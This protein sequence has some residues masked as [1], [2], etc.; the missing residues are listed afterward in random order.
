MQAD[1]PYDLLLENATATATASISSHRISGFL[2]E[3]L[4]P[5]FKNVTAT[6][7]AG[8]EDSENF[9]DALFIACVFPDLAYADDSDFSLVYQSGFF[10]DL[11]GPEIL[12]RIVVKGFFYDPARAFA[13]R[14]TAA[15]RG[16]AF[17]RVARAAGNLWE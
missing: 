15:A 16:P 13:A 9:S 4:N 8:N 5:L 14:A 1:L 12:C 7:T 3:L 10:R 11:C 6:A 2:I 17:A